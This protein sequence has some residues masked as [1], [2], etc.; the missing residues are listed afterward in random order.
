MEEEK[1]KI[2]PH[3]ELSP[4][5]PAS[6]E[7]E[8]APPLDWQPAIDNFKWEDADQLILQAMGLKRDSEELNV[9]N[10]E[11][12]RK[13]MTI[14]IFVCIGVVGILTFYGKIPGEAFTG[15]LGVL[16]GHLLSKR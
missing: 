12:R 6:G 16:I 11:S 4:E 3:N 1:N 13:Y 8:K 14:I 7:G 9:E 15:F 10:S 5:T 2:V